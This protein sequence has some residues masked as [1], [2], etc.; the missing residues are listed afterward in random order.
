MPVIWVLTVTARRTSFA[1]LNDAPLAALLQASHGADGDDERQ[2]VRC[3]SGTT[4][5]DLGQDAIA[6]ISAADPRTPVAHS[7]VPARAH[8]MRRVEPCRQPTTRLVRAANWVFLLFG[9]GATYA[10]PEPPAFVLLVG[11]SA[12]AVASRWT[13]PGPV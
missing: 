13:L 11:T 9:I 5:H 4:S 3:S 2:K 12:Q 6:R 8:Q 7:G 10:V 1:R